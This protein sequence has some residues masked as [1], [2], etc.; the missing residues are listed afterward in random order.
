MKSN[1]RTFLKFAEN[2]DTFITICLV[3]YAVIEEVNI[4][5]T[6]KN[7]SFLSFHFCVMDNIWTKSSMQIY[8]R[9]PYLYVSA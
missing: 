3:H 7:A 9:L 2:T 8:V 1:Y 4:L 5:S 6:F